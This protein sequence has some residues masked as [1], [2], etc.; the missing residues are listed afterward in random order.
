[1][2]IHPFYGEDSHPLLWADS[3]TA[4][5]NIKICG[6][7]NCLNYCDI[8]WYINSVQMWQRAA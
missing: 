8:L 2:G 3:R 7:P 1:M 4:R 6:T 5:G